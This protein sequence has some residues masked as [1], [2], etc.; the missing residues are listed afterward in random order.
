LAVIN[1]ERKIELLCVLVVRI[2]DFWT[3]QQN[4]CFDVEIPRNW[5]YL[6]S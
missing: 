5:Q 6:A 1:I 4:V 3:F 2:G